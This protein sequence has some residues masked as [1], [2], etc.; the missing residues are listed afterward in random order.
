M[1]ALLVSNFF[2]VFGWALLTPLYALYATELGASP[3]LVTLSWSFYT[4]LAGVL[5]IV[6]G[7]AED[8]IKGKQFVLTSGYI[9]ELVGLG[10]LFF[11][12]DVLSLL[13]GLGIYAVGTGVVMPIWKVL[14][15][16]SERKGREAAGWGFFHGINTL[17]I[18]A[19]AAVSGFLFVAF[20]FKG[21]LWAMMAV[22]FLAATVSLYV[23]KV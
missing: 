4:L 22:Q 9:I 17:L 16:K 19:A 20:G 1:I 11:A 15:A 3:Q 8:H 12:T 14:Y 7:W 21:I 5:M 23:K 13:W 18:S 2:N 10:V 6:L